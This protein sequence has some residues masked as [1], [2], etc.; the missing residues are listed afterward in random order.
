MKDTNSH[1]S[2]RQKNVT[3]LAD[4]MAGVMGSLVALWAF[5]PMDV[6][7]TNLQAQTETQ[8]SSCSST[9]TSAMNLF[10]GLHIKTL[11]TAAS[12]FCYFYIHSY[13]VSMFQQQQQQHSTTMKLTLSAIAAMMNTFLTLP[14]DVIASRHQ[15]WDPHQATSSQQQ[16]NNSNDND[17]TTTNVDDNVQDNVVCA[18]PNHLLPAHLPSLWKGLIPS[19]LLCT[20]PAIHYTVFDVLKSRHS[21]RTHQPLSMV[22]AFL[23]GLAAKFIA[24]IST[25]PL[26]RAKLMLMVTTTTTS[27]KTNNPNTTMLKCLRDEYTRDGIRA[28]YTGCNLQLLHTVLKS[29]LMMMV[30]E[31][32]AKTTHRLLIPKTSTDTPTGPTSLS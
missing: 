27:R 22:D 5:Y 10:R 20:N 17:T 4:A 25:Y 14:L 12:S 28:W 15:T 2:N 24:T 29:A 23:L 3:A 1:R 16:S 9:S 19:L 32:I 11:H 13:I 7:K 21:R 31:R 18:V 8:T 6:I 30:R 26:I